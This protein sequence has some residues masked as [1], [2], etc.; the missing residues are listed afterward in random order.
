MKRVITELL[1]NL[2]V[3]SKKEKKQGSKNK[4]Q[5]SLV[6]SCEPKVQIIL[7]LGITLI[8]SSESGEWAGRVDKNVRTVTTQQ[9]QLS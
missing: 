9:F 4:F 2:D 8:L 7:I 3:A 6:K 1:G 5:E